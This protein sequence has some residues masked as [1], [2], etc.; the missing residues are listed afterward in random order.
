MGDSADLDSSLSAAYV[1]FV[2]AGSMNGNNLVRSEDGRPALFKMPEIGAGRLTI[3]GGLVDMGGARFG[4]NGSIG[5]SGGR[6]L[7]YE[8]AA[9]GQIDVVSRSDI[10][11]TG[12]EV[13]AISN[14]SLT[15][16]QIYPTTGATAAIYAGKYVYTIPGTTNSYNSLVPGGVV[17]FHKLEGATPAAPLSLYGSLTVGADIINQ[18]G[19]AA[20]AARLDRSGRRRRQVCSRPRPAGARPKL[21]ERGVG[22]DFGSE[23]AARQPD[24]GQ[25]QGSGHSLRRDHR[26]PDLAPER[27]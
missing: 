12:G 4:V 7:D 23:P 10:R 6:Q 5:L 14:I 19:G 13:N 21:L 24:L 26:R 20:R 27:R 22:H 9:H 11:M 16:A 3:T 1:R 18:G 8:Y 15:A 2:A 17:S 25:R